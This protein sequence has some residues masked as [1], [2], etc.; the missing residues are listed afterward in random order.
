MDPFSLAPKSPPLT[1]A[2]CGCRGD[3]INAPDFAEGA[4]IPDPARLVKAY[5][6][7]AATLNL[8]RGFSTGK[9]TWL[10]SSQVVLVIAVM[11]SVYAS[12]ADPSDI[13]W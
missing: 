7:S 4:R 5:N 3:I 8:L 6:Q 11:S 10:A 9:L 2:P 12:S 13:C 1:H